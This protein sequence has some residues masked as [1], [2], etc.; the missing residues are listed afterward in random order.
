MPF[1]AIVCLD[2]LLRD[3]DW[4]ASAFV[5]DLLRL[6]V[7]HASAIA[8]GRPPKD[9]QSGATGLTR[10]FSLAQFRA[11]CAR[12]A[13][14]DCPTL[15]HALHHRVP[16]AAAAY[17]LRHLPA[18][19]LVI[20][21][22]MPPWQSALLDDAGIAWI[23]LRTSPLRFGS[24]LI[25]GLATNRAELHAAVQP[26][27]MRPDEVAAEASLM[28]ARL[29]LCARRQPTPAPALRGNPSVFIGQNEDDAALIGP[30]G[31]VARASDHRDTLYRLARTGPMLYLPHPL[32]GDFARIEHLAI[33]RATGHRV[34]V[35]TMDSYA[36]LASDEALTLV[37]LNAGLLHEA[38]WF[39]RAAHALCAPQAPPVFDPAHP[40]GGYL[41]IASHVLLAEPLWASLLDRPARK[42]PLR[43]PARANLLRELTNDWWGYADTTLRGS[44]HLQ[45]GFA[46]AGGQRHGEALRRCEGELDSNRQA[47][48]AIRQEID[49]LREQLR[50]TAAIAAAAAS[51]VTAGHAG[52]PAG[53]GHAGAMSAHQALAA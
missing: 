27:A 45:A 15:W 21:H 19:A 9:G 30:S 33:E 32:A 4:P 41:Q 10:G 46:I 47:L 18:D 42:A 24:D 1:S 17:L 3:D 20:G 51:A 14:P 39:G 49:Q 5:F 6:P 8:I 44:A 13:R 36:L 40:P 25:M 37:G 28:A 11:L 26:H 16:D 31:R 12:D 23:D 29:R 7:F 52:P 53:I 48:A 35:C 50:D 34:T 2:D 22:R 43:M 38:A